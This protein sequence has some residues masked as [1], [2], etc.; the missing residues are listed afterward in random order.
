[1]NTAALP[2]TYA[3]QTQTPSTLSLIA[4]KVMNALMESRA[5]SAAFRLRRYEA[6]M[7]D[8]KRRQDHSASFLMQNNDLPFKI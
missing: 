5:R 6:L 8:L 2:T 3:V 1:M 7:A 4:R